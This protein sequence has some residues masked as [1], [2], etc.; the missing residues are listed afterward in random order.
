MKVSPNY[1]AQKC[2]LGIVFILFSYTAY[3]SDNCF[4]PTITNVVE[5]NI[6]CAMDVLAW[7]NDKA[8]SDSE[9]KYAVFKQGNYFGVANQLGSIVIPARYQELGSQFVDNFIPAKKDN[10]WGYV[11][12]HGKEVIPLVYDW[13]P[14]FFANSQLADVTVEGKS[15]C[16]DMTGNI[17]VPISY[18]V[19]N[20]CKYHSGYEA[21][22]EGEWLEVGHLKD[23]VYYYGCIDKKAKVIVPLKYAS[24][25]CH[26]GESVFGIPSRV[27]ENYSQAIDPKTNLRGLINKLGELVIPVVYD[28]LDKVDNHK[29]KVYKNDE[30]YILDISK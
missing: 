29:I 30:S 26:F 14:P 17:I 21:G 13:V 1:N 27:G 11:D 19:I 15:G 16:I 25:I 12:I 4:K 10:K 6:S 20:G 24:G 5:K 23:G 3:A 18:D 22:A 28:S 7:N 9:D 8:Q 2:L